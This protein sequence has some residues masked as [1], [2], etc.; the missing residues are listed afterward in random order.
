MTGDVG[1]T[2]QPSGGVG[3]ANAPAPAADS[4]EKPV[5]APK[6][7]PPG[8][9]T[10]GYDGR[11]AGGSPPLDLTTDF[12]FDGM[13][14][15]PDTKPTHD[16]VALDFA[17]DSAATGD[18]LLKT[19][20][21]RL[22]GLK[23][24]LK[25]LETQ[26]LEQMQKS[27]AKKAEA[28]KHKKLNKIFGWLGVALGGI[29]SL[30]TMGAGSALGGGLIVMSLALTGTQTA[31]QESGALN[32]FAENHKKGALAVT[33]SFTVVQFVLAAMSLKFCGAKDTADAVKGIKDLAT[34]KALVS[35]LADIGDAT[36]DGVAAAGNTNAEMADVLLEGLDQATQI[37]NDLVDG[38][39]ASSASMAKTEAAL[40]G[41]KEGVKEAAETT[42]DYLDDA[43]AK[44]DDV[45]DVADSGSFVEGAETGV[46][47][48]AKAAEDSMDDVIAK[49]ADD[50]SNVADSGPEGAAKTGDTSDDIVEISDEGAE[51]TTSGTAEK[52]AA[53]KKKETTLDQVAKWLNRGAVL[54]KAGTDT[55]TFFNSKT[56]AKLNR[57]IEDIKAEIVDLKYQQKAT[58]MHQKDAD[59]TVQK[60]IEFIDDT[61]GVLTDVLQEDA[62][63][64]TKAVTLTPPSQTR[65]A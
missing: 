20:Q 47:D 36:A 56:L 25:H 59:K 10:V 55:G 64:K 18:E 45:A 15:A 40:D 1:A 65:T 4:A 12:V 43:I 31:L 24:M 32:K 60:I 30:A 37:T 44:A 6:S 52:A 8:D 49:E 53:D 50:L 39:V 28:K 11:P 54:T 33:I 41:V 35:K 13:G 42:G 62:Q 63:T 19:L 16:E 29:M 46:K 2:G 21:G 5:D 27:S 26:R 17:A 7:S 48:A 3:G 14:P 58:T 22:D 38:A 9:L 23:K 34:N 61:F 57:A 51:T